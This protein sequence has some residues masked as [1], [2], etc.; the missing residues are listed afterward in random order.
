MI[1]VSFYKPSGVFESSFN[2]MAA[3][4]TG[5]NYCH[6]ELVFCLEPSVLM[7]VVKKR[8]QDITN[9]T[10]LSEQQKIKNTAEL[11][12]VFFENKDHR[13]IIQKGE[14]VYVSFSLLWG[15]QLR[16]RFLMNIHDPWI[17]KPQIEFDDVNWIQIDSINQKDE[18]KGFLWSLSEITK[19]YNNSAAFWSWLPTWSV[20]GIQPKDSYFC[21]E[22]AAM[23]L[24]YMGHLKPMSV[25]H[26]T[27]NHLWDIL[28]K[29]KK[30][31]N[32]EL[33]VP[34]EEEEE[35]LASFVDSSD[36]EDEL[37]EL[38]KKLLK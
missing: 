14:P 33:E 8:Y 18:E 32:V 9:D 21:S 36:E 11:E 26:C 6:C 38:E 5:G 15:D 29:Q 10:N 27:P 16:V 28:Q 13:A 19:P 23:V 2:K 35:T 24:V 7:N 12:S 3:W 20:D 25:S 34:E 1:W 17:A 31:I 37:G 4:W 22:F 30:T